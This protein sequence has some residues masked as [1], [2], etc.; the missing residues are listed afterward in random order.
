MQI[1]SQTFLV[2]N[3][4]I[5]T[6]IILWINPLKLDPKTAIEG[7]N[8]RLL[9]F[10]MIGM[11]LKILGERAWGDLLFFDLYLSWNCEHNLRDTTLDK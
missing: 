5:F 10:G 8:R 7:K 11:I 3:G 9:K 6:Q 4:C 2:F 1:V